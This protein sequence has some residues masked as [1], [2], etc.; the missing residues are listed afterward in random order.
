VP[1]YVVS[2]VPVVLVAAWMA[3]FGL[4]SDTHAG[5]FV[6]TVYAPIEWAADHS[7]RVQRAFNQIGRKVQ[8]LFPSR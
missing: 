3:H 2:I 6:A 4:V 7:E 5:D 1:L 8:P